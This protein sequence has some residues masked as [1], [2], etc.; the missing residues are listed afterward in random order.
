[1]RQ[2]E[3]RTIISSPHVSIVTSIVLIH[4]TASSS[5]SFTTALS[6]TMPFAA[7]EWKCLNC[8]VVL[9]KKQRTHTPCG[10]LTNW[11]CLITE[12]SGK[13]DSYRGHLRHCEYC[14]P[15]LDHAIHAEREANKENRMEAVE[16]DE[17]GQSYRMDTFRTLPFRSLRRLLTPPLPAVC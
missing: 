3:T 17:K 5:R 2:N 7:V 16:I 10:E 13:Y 11:T 1:M 4:Y 12:Q 8:D 14:S 15:D 6:L 9:S